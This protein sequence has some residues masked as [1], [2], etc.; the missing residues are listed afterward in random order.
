MLAIPERFAVQDLRRFLL[1][2]WIVER[3]IQDARAETRGHFTG[4]AVFS[5]HGDDL[6]YFEK[7][8]LSYGDH[9]SEAERS[10]LFAFPRQ[11]RAEVFFPDGRAFHDLS[12]SDGAWSASHDCPPDVYQGSF[13]ALEQGHWRSRWQ[14]SGPR[15]D[16]VLSTDYRR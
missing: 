16:Q 7:G 6:Q 15:K 4:V 5:P 10:Y 12:L 14:V 3:V 2:E 11:A 1:G 13:E 9:R 8:L